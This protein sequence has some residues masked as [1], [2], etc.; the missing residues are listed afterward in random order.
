M[1]SLDK[2]H[3][4]YIDEEGDAVSFDSQGINNNNIRMICTHCLVSGGEL[5]SNT[6]L[7]G[8]TLGL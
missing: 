4:K 7:G 2:A 6:H 1:T 3:L 5:T 8:F